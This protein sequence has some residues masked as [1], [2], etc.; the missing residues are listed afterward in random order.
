MRPSLLPR[1]NLARD[2]AGA[3]TE[4]PPWGQG[5]CDLR[6]CF[7]E[8]LSM[9]PLPPDHSCDQTGQRSPCGT[10]GRTHTCPRCRSSLCP[11]H[12]CQAVP[13]H[14][15]HGGLCPEPA[16]LKPVCRQLPLAGKLWPW[17]R[18]AGSSPGLRC[19]CSHGCAL[20]QRHGPSMRGKRWPSAELGL[21][22]ACPSVV[23]GRCSHSGLPPAL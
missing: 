7:L 17:L 10:Q 23:L 14:M 8:G 3:T 5:S 4:A 16:P 11:F 2:V 20:G 21:D 19:G 13:V 18:R 12:N 1:C 6:A 22:Q 15:A 9:F